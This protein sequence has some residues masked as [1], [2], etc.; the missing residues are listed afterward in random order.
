MGAAALLSNQCTQELVGIDI[1]RSSRS[2]SQSGLWRWLP[3][4]L[5]G[6][7]SHLCALLQVLH[8]RLQQGAA[9][10]EGGFILDGFPRWEQQQQ[11]QCPDMTAAVP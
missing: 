10:G 1:N 8:H 9:A 5:P 7:T 11:Q 4:Q 3:E 6:L 2:R